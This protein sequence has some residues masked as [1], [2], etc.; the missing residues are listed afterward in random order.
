MKKKIISFILALAMVFTLLPSISLPS[1]A[2][3]T[4]GTYTYRDYTSY[5]GSNWNPHTWTDSHDSIIMDYIQTPLVDITIKDSSTGE[6]QWV[7]LAASDI[8]DV[9]ASHQDDLLTYGANSSDAT[10]GYVYEISLNPELCWEDGTPINADT[11]IYSMQQLLDPEAQNYRA[12]NFVSGSAAIAG[13]E[14]YYNQGKSV[15][16]ENSLGADYTVADLV[17]GEDGAY[18]TPDGAAVYIAVSAA[19]ENWLGGNSLADYIN[20]YGDAYFDLTDWDALCALTNDDGYAVLTDESMGYLVTTIAGNPSWGETA[21]DVPYYLSYEIIY[22]DAEWDSVGL[23]KVDD[24]T[25]RY[26]CKSYY[27]YC[28]FLTSMTSN[29]IVY[30]D[31][32]EAGNY[33]T[34]AET[35]MS[36]GPYSIESYS[37]EQMVFTRNENYYEYDVDANGNITSTTSFTVDGGQVSQWETD[38]II[39]TVMNDEEAMAAFLNGELDTW[40]PSTSEIYDY[41]AS[42]RLYQVD[43]TYTYRL[44]FNCDLDALQDMDENYGNTN[45]V[46]M[47]NHNFREALSLSINRDELV[48][49]TPGYKSALTLLNSLYYYDVYNDPSSVYRN[50]TQAKEAICDL[51]GV[52]YS[53]AN[54]A[55][56][57]GYDLSQAQALM[58]TACQELVEAGLYTEGEPIVIRMGWSGGAL[59]TSDLQQIALLNKYINAAAEGSGFGTIS[60]R[61]EGYSSRYSDVPDGTLAIGLGAWG[62]AAFYPFNMLRL[63]CDPNYTWLHEAGCYDPTSETLTLN[64]G[65][66]DVTMTWQAWSQS[67]TIGV[68]AK[69][70]MDVKLEVLAKLEAAFL[71][72]YYCIPMYSK[73]SCTM[74]SYKVDYFTSNYNIMY[75][76]GGMRLLRYNYTDTEWDTYVASGEL[77]YYAPGYSGDISDLVLDS[78]VCGDDLTWELTADSTLTISGTG[79]MYDFTWEELAPWNSY[80]YDLITS[81]VVEDGV[82]SI[83]DLAF[84]QT[85]SVESVTLPEGLTSVGEYAFYNSHITAVTLPSTLTT[86]EMYAFSYSALETVAIPAGLNDIATDAFACIE[87]LREFTVEEG[88]TAFSAVDGVLLSADGTNLIQYPAAKDGETYTVPES[89]TRVQFPGFV[90]A[91][92]LTQINFHENVSDI[93]TDSLY[94]CYSM[95]C[96]QVAEGNENYSTGPSGELLSSDG[97]TLY[98]YPLGREETSYTVPDGVVDIYHDAFSFS[99]LESVTLSDS[100]VRIYDS[101]FDGCMSLT[102]IDL[103]N[104]QYLYSAVFQNCTSLQSITIPASVVYLDYALFNCCDSLETVYFEGNAPE[105]QDEQVFDLNS[106]LVFTAYYPADNETWTE[107]VMQNYGA[108]SV[109]WVAFNGFSGTCGENVTWVF[110]PATGTLTISGTGDMTN[111]YNTNATPWYALK[112]LIVHVVIEDGVTSIGDHAFSTFYALETAAI[113][114]SVTRIE[115]WAFYNCLHMDT[116]EIPGNVTY[117]GEYAFYACHGL[118]TVTIPASVTEIGMVAFADSNSLTAIYVEDGNTAYASDSNGWLY[119]KAMDTLIAVPTATTGDVVI[120]EGV[121]AIDYG[122][123]TGCDKITGIEIPEGVETIGGWEFYCCFGLESMTI[124]ASVTQIG[125]FAFY[126]C[127]NLDKVIF[128]GDAP[129]F[130]ENAFLELSLTAYYPA[131]NETWTEDVMQDYGAASISWV[132]YDG[133]IPDDDE[134]DEDETTNFCG[135]NVTWSFDEASG[136][137]TISGSGAM[138]NYSWAETAP[139]H[140]FSNSIT[141]IVVEEGV[142]SV[143]EYAFTD[144]RSLESVTLPEGLTYIG[145]YAFAWGSLSEIT[146]PETLTYIGSCVFCNTN[147]TSVHI[148]AATSEFNYAAFDACT[149]LQEFTVAEGNPTVTAV[150]GVLL[151][152]DMTTLIQYPAA[153]SGTSYT[154][155]ETVV[156]ICDPGFAYAQNLTEIN[157]HENVSSISANALRYGPAL[158]SI[159]VDT[160]NQYYSS[161]TCG[162]LMNKTG[163]TLYV[164]PIGRADTSYTVPDGVTYIEDWTFQDSKLE[165]ILLP[166]SLVSLGVCVFQCCT[167][168]RTITIPAGITYI[169]SCTF[170]VCDSLESI[171]FEGDAPGFSSDAFDIN[172]RLVVTVY[173]PAGNDTWTEDVMQNYGAASVTWVAYEAA[174]GGDEE[175][176]DPCENG[177]S[178]DAVVTDATCTEQGYTTHTCSVCGDS[179]VDSY[180]NALGHDYVDGICTRCGAEDESY[181]PGEDEEPSGVIFGDL[182][183]DEEVDLVDATMII[184]YYNETI[185][186]TDHQLYV[187][188]LNV[189]DE[190]DIVDALL[191]IQYYNEEI[192]SFPADELA[193]PTVTLTLWCGESNQSMLEDAVDTFIEDHA[194]KAKITVNFEN[195]NE[196]SVT[197]SL[198]NDPDGAD[199]F[200]Y[201]S[202]QTMP[203][204]NA[205]LLEII[206][207]EDLKS[208][209]RSGNDAGSVAAA[210][211][212]GELYAMPLYVSNGYF[213]YYDDSVFSE[214]DL[215]SWEAMLEA[216]EAAGKVVAMDLSNC[217][218]GYGFFGGAGMP[219]S[220]TADGTNS[221]EWDC[222]LGVA[223]SEYIIDLAAHPAF[224]A[225]S[226]AASELADSNI[227]AFVG[228]TWSYYSAMS[229]WGDNYGACKLPT[230][231]LEDGTTYQMGSFGGSVLVGINANSGN[232]DLAMELAAFLTNEQNQLENFRSYNYAPSNRN[233]AA[234]SVVQSN[235]AIAAMIAQAEYATPQC[236]G[237]NFWGS[238]SSLFSTLA[239]GNPDGTD[240]LELLTTA[241]SGIRS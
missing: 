66:S 132:A 36:Y 9:T 83:G 207:D 120:P 167:E 103:N 6:Y 206:S 196:G 203:L 234:N 135:E 74:M 222:E 117:I 99:D 38:K 241:A 183:G 92:N 165:T 88:N 113:P 61:G 121:T 149:T 123:F 217:W 229:A 24:Y 110:D 98:Q 204:V 232:T 79:D 181:D 111:F 166:D 109:T 67:T 21:A 41:N 119:N 225:T 145:S 47:S 195:V 52:S 55:A 54:Y 168:L 226:N 151:S 15:M 164:Y 157:I 130:G 43:E 205:G 199:L 102:S 161:G 30:Q 153:K 28:Y 60:I 216:A 17:L 101:A 19:L 76:F 4:S 211:V 45:S 152:A 235:I 105:F 146:L 53:E 112:D 50:S 2:A 82:T 42:P 210:T 37:G 171:Y 125:E 233:A 236:V 63:Y 190:I 118:T 65:G 27:E 127:T 202:D 134:G 16:Q 186:L 7:F 213:M 25:I 187:A 155:P 156:T 73:T 143:G 10:S 224:Y 90:M 238:A 124:P 162:E 56:L 91:Q 12:N 57:T 115:N 231:T 178:Y 172:N 49:T 220:M 89:V 174:S 192:S 46:V 14:G 188:D 116:V 81:I 95:V 230:F 107:E 8:Q 71:D 20:A 218:Y 193:L 68:Y 194:D 34:S 58:A 86:V 139:W 228:G 93:S 48:S 13:A 191:I 64:I 70:D 40:N 141:N 173:Y 198:S 154:I 212:D 160:G 94:Y 97:T 163:T 87:N 208:D 23:Y 197:T 179:Y 32:Y 31:L 138:Y 180:T 239:N 129:A 44:F 5:L 1:A 78:G 223:V 136:T 128:T 214:E 26:V 104:V 122:A 189:D 237:A 59:T 85:A 18:Y 29:W 169:P 51:Y 176:K 209:I 39:Y 221:C 182:N 175:E 140:S 142:T 133:S 201:S 69:E 11:Y 75:G 177:H 3:G 126:Y 114:D 147:L 72:Q 131:G 184:A 200:L 185:N 215:T 33:C 170:N 35:T 227:C 148:P 158:A 77:S 137:L 62:G 144:A 106:S 219:V 159:N 240:L 84:F 108:A 100:V 96:F 150:D 80:S 22:P